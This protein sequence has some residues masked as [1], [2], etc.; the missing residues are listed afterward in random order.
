MTEVRTLEE[1][2]EDYGDVVWWCWRDGAWLGEAA[3]IGTPLD[4][5]RGYELSI[6]GQSSVVTLG[7]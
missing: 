5:G 7:G 3:Y 2:H 4:L 6:G 1:W